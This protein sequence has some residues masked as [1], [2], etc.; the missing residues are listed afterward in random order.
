MSPQAAVPTPPVRSPLVQS[1]IEEVRGE[2][3]KAL[4]EGCWQRSDLQKMLDLRKI[5][6]SQA[7]SIILTKVKTVFH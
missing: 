6:D 4:R 1:M 3:L 7:P 2:V 5:A